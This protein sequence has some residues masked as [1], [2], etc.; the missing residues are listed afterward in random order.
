[1]GP[2]SAVVTGRA[3]T[4]GGRH[5]LKESKKKINP[6][7]SYIAV[8]GLSRKKTNNFMQTLAEEYKSTRR[9]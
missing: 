3:F 8:F 1:M 2:N 6:D 9:I 5:G 7:K 4:S